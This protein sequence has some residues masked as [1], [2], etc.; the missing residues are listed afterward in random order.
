M[1][2]R[3]DRL[4]GVL[5]LVFT[6]CLLFA[7]KT[8]LA[9]DLD[10][11]G[12]P[13]IK[14]R[15]T[16]GD[17]IEIALKNHPMITEA[18]YNISAATARTLAAKAM[19]KPQISATMFGGKSSMGDIIASPPQISPNNIFSIPS[20]TGV[21]AQASLML[22]IYTGSKLEYAIANSRLLEESISMN[23][24]TIELDISYNVQVAYHQV[25]LNK[26]ASEIIASLV[27]E[28]NERVRISEVLFNEG[29]IAKYDLLRNQT[30]SADARQQYSN[31]ERDQKVSM[32]NL[33]ASVGISRLSEVTLVDTFSYNVIKSPL[34]AL[35][36]K[37]IENRPELAS[38]KLK[39]KAAEQKIRYGR[40]TYKPQVYGVA[41]QSVIAGSDENQSG[42]TVGVT[43]GLPIID[44]GSRRAEI[45]ES[46]AMYESAKNDE[47]KML[48]QIQQEVQTAFEELEVADKNVRISEAV[49]N[50]TEDYRVIKLRYEAGKAVNVEVLDTLVSL[51]KARNNRIIALHEYDIASDKLSRAIGEQIK[52]NEMKEETK[53]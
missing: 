7:A 4:S 33:F 32:I 34:D 13:I 19:T 46:K 41:M 5:A 44:G 42:Y 38:L 8:I 6:I 17:A 48:I 45:N 21:T 27:S 3:Y 1:I 23:K 11:Y 51:I 47:K 26:A 22:P 49:T 39:T 24:K 25:L 29:K 14:G 30:L 50:A 2:D 53:Q 28:T 36:K 12:L 35:I 40:S 37:A 31:A 9:E 16:V 43:V 15:L 10:E 20:Q 52:S 18:Q